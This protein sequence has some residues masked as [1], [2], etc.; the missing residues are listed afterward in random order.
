MLARIRHGLTRI[1]ELTA[2]P[3]ALATRTVA[4]DSF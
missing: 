1:G 4:V 2:H 3:A